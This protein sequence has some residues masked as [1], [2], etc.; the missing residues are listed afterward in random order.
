MAEYSIFGWTDTARLAGSV[1]GVV[2]QIRIEL[3]SSGRSNW[4]RASSLNRNFTKTEILVWSLYSISASA[5]A[6]AQGIDQ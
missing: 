6:V 3:S 4:V 2:V 1:Q 5:S